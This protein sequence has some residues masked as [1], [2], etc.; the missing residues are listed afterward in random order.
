MEFQNNETVISKVYIKIHHMRIYNQ[1][2]N[3]LIVLRNNICNIEMEDL[4]TN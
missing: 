4:Q 1:L 2:L 3:F